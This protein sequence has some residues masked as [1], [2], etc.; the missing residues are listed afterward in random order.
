MIFKNQRC[1][2]CT[3]VSLAYS[4]E[5]PGRIIVSRAKVLL[6]LHVGKGIGVVVMENLEKKWQVYQ[7]SI[8]WELSASREGIPFCGPR[9]GIPSWIHAISCELGL[10]A[11]ESYFVR[12]RLSGS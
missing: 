7:A 2:S 4:Q 1:N 3:F 8:S 5:Q 9:E 12:A 11:R 10:L 6:G